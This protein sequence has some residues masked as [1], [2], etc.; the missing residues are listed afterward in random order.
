MK[1]ILYVLAILLSLGQSVGGLAQSTPPAQKMSVNDRLTK[2][3]AA[4]AEKS[5]NK[6]MPAGASE[7]KASP[8]DYKAPVDKTQKGPHGEVVHTGE[9]GGKF[10]INANGNKTYL[11]SNQ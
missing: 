9:Q 1:T 8:A 5:A 10:Y 11:S 3:R 4:K 6:A 7:S 2:A